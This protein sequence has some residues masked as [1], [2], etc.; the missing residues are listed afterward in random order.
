MPEAIFSDAVAELIELVE[1][2][3]DNWRR[4]WSVLLDD[5]SQLQGWTNAKG[6]R[7]MAQIQGEH[8]CLSLNGIPLICS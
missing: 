8:Y 3:Q 1:L 7:L 2:P 6:D 4:Q 5:G